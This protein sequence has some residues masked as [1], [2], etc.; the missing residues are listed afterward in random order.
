MKNTRSFLIPEVSIVSFLSTGGTT[1][2]KK[3]RSQEKDER[4]WCVCVGAGT[5]LRRDG[6]GGSL[7]HFLRSLLLSLVGVY[8]SGNRLQRGR[9][10]HWLES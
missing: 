10:A 3:W 9:A 7:R 1:T 2:I 5:G 4:L 8:A 6:G